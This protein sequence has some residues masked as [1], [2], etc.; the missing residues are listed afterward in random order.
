MAKIKLFLPESSLPLAGCCE[1]PWHRRLKASPG[2]SIYPLQKGR[3]SKEICNFT[4][5]RKHREGCLLSEN[6]MLACTSNVSEHTDL[7]FRKR[8]HSS[9][10]GSCLSVYN[11]KY[12]NTLS[13]FPCLSKLD[14]NAQLAV[15]LMAL[16]QVHPAILSLKACLI[17]TDTIKWVKWWDGF[18]NVLI[19]ISV[20]P[21]DLK[22][23]STKFVFKLAKKIGTIKDIANFLVNAS[24][25]LQYLSV[26]FVQQLICYSGKVTQVDP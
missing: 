14:R 21:C 26:V 23:E 20:W 9:L 2:F 18:T 5:Q 25:T 19:I 15:E 8:L 12:S 4:Y 11:F 3:G 16:L 17:Q 6:N 7:G 24:N 10:S 13:G 1:G 22:S